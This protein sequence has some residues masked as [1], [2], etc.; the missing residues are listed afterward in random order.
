VDVA[1]RQYQDLRALPLVTDGH[2]IMELVPSVRSM[3]S[4]SMAH[5]LPFLTKLSVGSP[6]SKPSS[7]REQAAF[8]S[9]TPNKH[10][11]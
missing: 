10:V 1:S 5:L 8:H 11:K 6:G 4:G 7:T 3:L 9:P 2:I